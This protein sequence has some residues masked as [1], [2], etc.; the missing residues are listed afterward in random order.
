M[1]AVH[2]DAEADVARSELFRALGAAVYTPPP[3]TNPLTDALLLPTLTPVDHT[4]AFVLMAPPHAAIHLGAEGKLGGQALD[5]VDGFWRAAGASAPADA[6]HLGVLLMCYAGLTEDAVSPASRRMANALFHEHIWPWAPGYLTALVTL[7]VESVSAW[8]EL[9]MD[10]LDG[11]LERLDPPV[12][13][14]LALREAPSD[15]TADASFDELLDAVVA[16]VRTGM[17]LSHVDLAAGAAAI[18]A[19]YRRGERRYALK[20]MLEQDK[21]ATLY[22]LA[23]CAG[24]W[25]QIHAD[26]ADETSEWWARRAANSKDVFTQLSEAVR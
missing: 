26:R 8:A 9:T 6:D 20:A 21:A 11:E 4:H 15:L 2:A 10:V 12:Q 16:P 24:N 5:R 18:G 7:G 25:A 22:W 19:G 23:A 14:P 3:A 17:V 1:T 13:L